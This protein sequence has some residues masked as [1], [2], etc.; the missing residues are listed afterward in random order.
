MQFEQIDREGSP[1]EKEGDVM[2]KGKVDSLSEE[3]KKFVNEV[4]QTIN[5]AGILFGSYFIEAF[6]RASQAQDRMKTLKLYI[7]LK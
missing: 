5:V 6:E 7:Y 3:G 2:R 4:S 1:L